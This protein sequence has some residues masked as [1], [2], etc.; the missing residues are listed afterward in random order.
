[1]CP[2][3]SVIAVSPRLHHLRALSS[4]I[5]VCWEQELTQHRNESLMANIL[6]GRSLLSRLKIAKLDPE[7]NSREPIK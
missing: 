4:R 5:G 2:M 3:P 7:Y 1:M 6:N